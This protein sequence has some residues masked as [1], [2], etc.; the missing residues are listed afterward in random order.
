MFDLVYD[1]KELISNVFVGYCILFTSLNYTYSNILPGSIFG[2]I[3]VVN[4]TLKLHSL[5]F[6]H[7]TTFIKYAVK[8]YSLYKLFIFNL[9]YYYYF[10]IKHTK[11][12]TKN[13]EIV[14]EDQLMTNFFLIY[15]DVAVKADLINYYKY[16]NKE[17]PSTIRIKVTNLKTNKNYPIVIN[18]FDF[19]LSLTIDDIIDEILDN[20]TS[21]ITSSYSLHAHIA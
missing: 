12:I 19:T 3:Y 1:S 15:N 10:N 20:S 17:I 4:A 14:C 9:R 13:R 7:Q 18:N 21:C 5:Y 11:I 8:F 16:H 6:E 2:A